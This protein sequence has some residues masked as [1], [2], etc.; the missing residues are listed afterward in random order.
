MC[1]SD[2]VW[3]LLVLLVLAL[4]GSVCWSILRL[5][6]VTLLLFRVLVPFRAASLRS[7]SSLCLLGAWAVLTRLVEMPSVLRSGGS[8]FVDRV[9]VLLVGLLAGSLLASTGIGWKWVGISVVAVGMLVM[10]GWA[11]VGVASWTVGGS[12]AFSLHS[13]PEFASACSSTRFRIL[14]LLFRVLL[15]LWV[16]PPSIARAALLG[17][18]SVCL[19]RPCLPHWVLSLFFSLL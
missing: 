5:R 13:P 9:V 16:S 3:V 14:L 12:V 2:L 17:C 4:G 19:P 8:S 7:G 11:M 1:G 6:W 15:P 10:A 18:K